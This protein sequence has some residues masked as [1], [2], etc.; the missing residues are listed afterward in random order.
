MGIIS[1]VMKLLLVVALLAVGLSPCPG[2]G[3]EGRSGD[4]KWL[5]RS[6]VFLVVGRLLCN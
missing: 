1:L 6:S 4:G 3:Q 2:L 5:A